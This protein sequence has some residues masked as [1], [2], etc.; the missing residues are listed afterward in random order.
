VCQQDLTKPYLEASR[1]TSQRAQCSCVVGPYACVSVVRNPSWLRLHRVLHLVTSVCVG[2][3]L[4]QA[5]EALDTAA[6][7]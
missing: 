7:R 4:G 5:E 1:S 2:S 6:C 3:R